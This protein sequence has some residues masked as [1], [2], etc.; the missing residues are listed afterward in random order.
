MI[1]ATCD[2]FHSTQWS[3]L[4]VATYNSTPWLVLHVA[5]NNSTQWF[6]VLH[7]T[8]FI[9]EMISVRSGPNNGIQWLVLH[10][11]PTLVRND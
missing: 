9:V 5:T 1:S 8:P 11:I 3:A 6:L 4:H 7:V 2:T 10:V